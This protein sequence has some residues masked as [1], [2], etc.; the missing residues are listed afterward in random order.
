MKN[1]RLV[2]LAIIVVGIIIAF[3]VTYSLFNK[4]KQVSVN[5]TVADDFNSKIIREINKNE[6]KNYL[7]SPYSI[8][9]ALN[10]LRDGANGKTE[11]Q[12]NDVI[13]ERQINNLIIKDRINIANG[14]FIKDV[15]K[16]N[17]SKDYYHT[18]KTKYN[19]DILFD[20]FDTPKVINDWVN[21]ETN[22][23]IKEIITNLDKS[24]AMGIANAV[25][26]DVEWSQPFECANTLEEEFTKINNEKYKISM[27][28]NTYTKYSNAKYFKTNSEKGI[29]IPYKT[30]SE[31]E[32]ELY[33]NG[34]NLEFVGIL[35]KENIKDYISKITEETY[36][37]ID[38]NTKELNENEE[39]HLSLPMFKYEYE[40][41][42]LKS[43]LR[44]LGITDVFNPDLADLTS[45]IKVEGTNFYVSDAI[46]KAYIDLNEKGT[47]AAAVTAFVIKNTAMIDKDTKIIKMEFNKPFAYI[48]RDAKTKE[49]L[50]FGVVYEPI[51]WNGSTCK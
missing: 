37:R 8:E 20:K 40:V 19:A 24:F 11:K 17:V 14:A 29:I 51:K 35:P 43:N 48:I 49:M 23:M 3:G 22:G 33:E 21:K 44:N 36:K 34:N 6:D 39:I 42:D 28:H 50:F 41:E 30:Y 46:H 10:M 12:I 1:K 31:D 4:N 25:A 26:I 32:N 5:V 7:I 47:K 45:M 16:K 15:Y 27:M 9:V 18:L 38:N 2:L 13:R